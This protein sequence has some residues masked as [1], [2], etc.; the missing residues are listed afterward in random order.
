MEKMEKAVVS[1]T[2]SP[3]AFEN[4]GYI[5]LLIV[6][7]LFAVYIIT[8]IYFLTK[9][10]IHCAEIYA[11]PRDVLAEPSS[12]LHDDL[13]DDEVRDDELCSIDL[14]KLENDSQEGLWEESKV[15]AFLQSQFDV[16]FT[17]LARWTPLTGLPPKSVEEVDIEEL[18]AKEDEDEEAFL[19]Q[20]SAI[21][22]ELCRD[23]IVKKDAECPAIEELLT[24][25]VPA[26]AEGLLAVKEEGFFPQNTLHTEDLLEDNIIEKDDKSPTPICGAKKIKKK[27]RKSRELRRLERKIQ[28]IKQNYKIL[29]PPCLMRWD[30]MI[31]GPR[32]IFLINLVRRNI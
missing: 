15:I 4:E 30:S 2:Q 12:I 11:Q 23:N 28:Q 16:S 21:I 8:S 27:K 10:V 7:Y 6:I 22:E 26:E 5:F 19:L 14:T 9:T 3:E 1:R 18:V 25:D 32:G 13:I 17:P 29:A 31:A 20:K 24:N